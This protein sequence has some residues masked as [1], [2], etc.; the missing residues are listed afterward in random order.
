M[1]ALL[2]TGRRLGRSRESG[3]LA[4]RTVSQVL[5]LGTVGLAVVLL[6]NEGAGHLILYLTVVQV[7][8]LPV[9]AGYGRT[10]TMH[11]GRD[12]RDL[13]NRARRAGLAAGVAAGV[14]GSIVAVLMLGSEFGRFTVV[15]T[16]FASVVS[17]CVLL[18][19]ASELRG[20]MRPQ[21]S[22]AVEAIAPQTTLLL[23]LLALSTR[24]GAGVMIGRTVVLV[25]TA[26]LVDR[27][28]R[29]APAG[30]AAALTAV[31]LMSSVVAGSQILMVRLDLLMLGWLDG[32]GDVSA[33]SVIQRIAEISYWPMGA[34]LVVIGPQFAAATDRPS[35]SAA[36]GEVR[37]RLLAVRGL[38]VGASAVMGGVGAVLLNGSWPSTFAVLLFAS[39]VLVFF[40]PDA[41]LLLMQG[42]PQVVAL[43]SAVG[44]AANVALNLALIPPFGALGASFATLTALAVSYTVLPALARRQVGFSSWSTALR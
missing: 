25:L 44:V 17:L 36:V 13:A 9:G 38:A 19:R 30:S 12:E 21:W 22:T 40:A 23:A 31:S 34:A 7:A 41:S 18:L 14:I 1:R 3:V 20:E 11:I 8:A 26:V 5:G 2:E 4:L 33:Y 15:V 29:P 16:V 32:P 28:T 43:A 27:T 24:G 10:V 39:L 35:L 6:G 37:P 42:R